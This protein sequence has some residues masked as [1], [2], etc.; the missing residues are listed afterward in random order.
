[1]DTTVIARGGYVLVDAPAGALTIVA[2][3]SEVG[4]AVEAGRRLGVA[5]R[6]ARVVSM[7]CVERFLAQDGK[8]RDSVLAPGAPV[9]TIEAGRTT[10]WS[11]VTG[12]RRALHLGIDRF[13]ASAPAADLAKHLGFTPES[14]VERITQWLG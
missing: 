2:T 1:V 10:P 6:P 3:G 12:E 13:G 14:V 11:A 7:P 5:G 8:W 4:L 9:V